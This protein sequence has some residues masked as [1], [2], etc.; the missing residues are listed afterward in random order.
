MKLRSLISLAIILATIGL[1]S[2]ALATPFATEVISAI[3]GSNPQGGY[4]DSLTVLGSPRHRIPDPWGGDVTPF[5][6]EWK[7]DALWSIGAGGSLIVK[8][9]HRVFDNPDNVNWGFDFL[10]F[11]NA[12]YIDISYP[13][14][15]VNEHKSGNYEPGNI[16]VSQD[17]ILWY[18]V[19]AKA[20]VE[21]PTL[22]YTDSS[23]P[24]AVDGTI[25]S[26][27]TIPVDP[28]FDANNKTFAQLQDG[29]DGSGGGT[30]VDFSSTGLRW[31]QYV[32]VYQDSNNG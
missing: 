1:F 4:D 11:G 27:F 18:D 26:D 15:T 22:G 10:V 7:T 6:A 9:D 29:Y 21:F 25:E 16:Q 14:G 3:Q 31:I 20:D 2:Q 17:G 32:K 23:G 28:Y 30:S 5:N 8:F 19:T 13:D 24:Y 12:Y